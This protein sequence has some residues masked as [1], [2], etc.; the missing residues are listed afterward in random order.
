MPWL[1]EA[2]GTQSE[3]VHI[4]DFPPLNSLSYFPRPDFLYTRLSSQQP[5]LQQTGFILPVQVPVSVIIMILGLG[6]HPGRKLYL[7]GPRAHRRRKD[8]LS[9]R[10]ELGSE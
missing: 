10:L 4:M 5:A 1:Q 6:H 7:S 3:S 2:P 8:A 9:D